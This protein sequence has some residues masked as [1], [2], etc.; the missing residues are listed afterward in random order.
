MNIIHEFL[1][2]KNAPTFAWET[3]HGKE[4]PSGGKQGRA[5]GTKERDWNGHMVDELLKDEWLNALNNMK[6]IE[7][8]A[9]CQGHPPK[10]EWPS[11][12][13]FRQATKFNI[14]K[15]ISKIADKKTTFAAYDKGNQGKIRI[16]IA[17]PLY[18][19]GPKHKLWERWWETLAS[20]IKKA[21]R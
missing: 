8:R 11:F 19:K 3:V 1:K 13:I 17:T 18:A 12:I 14:D 4:H 6:E 2:K 16:C 20:N 7:V 5:P 21:T 9:S 10:D 15:F